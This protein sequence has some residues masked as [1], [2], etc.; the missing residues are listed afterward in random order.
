MSAANSS[1]SESRQ[2]APASGS[3][4]RLSS[5]VSRRPPVP[6]VY[7]SLHPRE[8][9]SG[10]ARSAFRHGSADDRFHDGQTD[11][12]RAPVAPRAPVKGGRLRTRFSYR[13]KSSHLCE[14][15]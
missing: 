10:S 4:R 7:V 9:A 13:P 14:R 15:A 5:V 3:D 6:T 2:T 11:F 8:P 12:R 1:L